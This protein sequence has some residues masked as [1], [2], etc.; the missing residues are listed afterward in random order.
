MVKNHVK[1]CLE[2]G[3]T[4]AKGYKNELNPLVKT[5]KNRA[6]I[7]WIW[8]SEKNTDENLHYTDKQKNA[9]VTAFIAEI[10]ND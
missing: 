4:A 3:V 1:I 2:A 7:E 9:F 10:L 5:I 8:F 6:I